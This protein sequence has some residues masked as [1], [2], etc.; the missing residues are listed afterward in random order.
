MP[1]VQHVHVGYESYGIPDALEHFE[2]RMEIEKN[3]FPITI[4]RWPRQERGSKQDRI[5]RLEPDIRNGRFIMPE[6][7]L[8]AQGRAT[9]DDT[10]GQ[11]A[12][13][14]AGQEFRI[15]KPQ[16]RLDHNRKL[17]SVH[18]TFMAEVHA[19]PYASH[20]DILDAVSRVYDMESLAPILMDERDT[21]P[22]IFGDGS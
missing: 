4:L 7:A 3:Y 21:E 16:F 22:P 15:F 13:R 11:Q 10:A 14:A 20:D 5:M 2:E 9:K 8:D 12:M 19:F 6:T 17:Y 1:G 18:G